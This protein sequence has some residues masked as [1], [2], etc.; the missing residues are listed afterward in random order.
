MQESIHMIIYSYYYRLVIVLIVIA[1]STG[2]AANTIPGNQSTGPSFSFPIQ[3]Y[4]QDTKFGPFFVAADP[5]QQGLQQAKQFA[6]ARVSR[7]GKAF[8]PLALE[9]ANVNG[10]ASAHNPLYDA[11][12]QYLSLLSGDLTHKNGTPLVVTAA[13]I[14]GITLMTQIIGLNLTVLSIPQI[15]DAVQLPT[16]GVVNISG[17]TQ[18]YGFAAVKPN[19]TSPSTNFGAVNS[20]IALFMFGTTEVTTP[21]GQEFKQPTFVQVDEPTGIIGP[22]RALPLDIT[23]PVVTI[24][25]NLAAMTDVV[26]LYWNKNLNCLYIGLQVQAAG[27]ATDGCKAIV[28]AHVQ[29]VK[30]FNAEKKPI[31]LHQLVFSQIAPDAVFTTAQNEIVGT[32]GANAQVSIQL[33]NALCT[34]SALNYLIIV[35]GNGAP[36]AT[37]NTVYAVPLVSGTKNNLINGTIASTSTVPVDIFETKEPHR[38]LVRTLPTPA[39]TPADMPLATDSAVL[40]GGGALAAG[41]ITDVFTRGDTVFVSVGNPAT[42]QLPGIFYS[43]A[44][45]D[46]NGKISSWTSWQR[47]GGTTQP[48]FGVGFDPSNGDFTFMTTDTSG[49]L[50]TVQRTSWGLGAS[51]GL[52]PLSELLSAQF[53]MNTLGV[54]GLFDFPPSCPGL[55]NIS[56]LVAT[57]PSKVAFIESGQVVAGTLVPNAG[58][59]NSIS[60]D[61][62]TIGTTLPTGPG[63]PKVVIISG[64]I[65]ESVGPLTCAEIARDGV[66]G[67]NGWLFVGGT[68]G[69]AVL[70]QADGTGWNAVAGLGP[71]FAGLTAGMSFK[72]VGSYS[73]VHK[74]VADGNFL[75]VLTDQQLDRIDLT[76][77]NVGLG[78][79]TPVTLASCPLLLGRGNNGSFMDLIVSDKL[80]LI[81][82]SLNLLRVG[83]GQDISAATSMDELQWTFVTVPESTGPVQELVV[84]TQ[85]GRMQDVARFNGGQMYVI[86]SYRG[87]NLGQLNRFFIAPVD[88][89]VIDDNTVQPLPD[90]FV[91]NIPSYFYNFS[92]LRT[93]FATDGALYISARDRE[94]VFA[95]EITVPMADLSLKNSFDFRFVGV[96]SVSLP[97]P[98]AGQSQLSAIFRNFS[99]GSWLISGEFGLQVNE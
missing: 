23:Q 57:G 11:G 6:I 40:V 91:Q 30:A 83:N 15:G 68:H 72:A 47:A 42:N 76:Q 55:A 35:G 95:P 96:R 26:P 9:F 16:T 61:D 10:Q 98:L 52:L 88:S 63:T 69:V 7:Q 50:D 33:L 82:T 37:T 75:Y 60:F 43:H 39:L 46:S 87:L 34:T 97:I 53:P 38:F 5:S 84:S 27:S 3:A 48:V 81:A 12:I 65:L 58:N 41:D 51:N 28:V 36:A 45:L 71:D 24:G 64:G 21:E 19:S 44:I 8:E 14:Q 18:S 62:G 32:L 99:S 31:I 89:A 85:T 29:Q 59:F 2:Y 54:S 90:L 80:G 77:G 86:N 49:I 78:V 93:L 56:A 25:S 94:L 73:F 66:S 70:S 4:A 22:M 79:I 67:N 20:G 17:S 92:A 13:N 74:L 1:H